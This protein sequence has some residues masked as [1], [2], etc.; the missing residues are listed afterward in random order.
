[1]APNR[2][3]CNESLWQ[4]Q[5]GGTVQMWLSGSEGMSPEGQAPSLVH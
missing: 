4:D 3:S 5:E 2:T 1:M